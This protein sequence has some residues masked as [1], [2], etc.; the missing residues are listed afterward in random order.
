MQKLLSLKITD[1]I[2][3]IITVSFV[4]VFGV[5]I[6]SIYLMKLSDASAAGEFLNNYFN[7]IKNGVNKLSVFKNSLWHNLIML[8]VMFVS[9]FF[10]IGFIAV[11]A[12]LARKGFIMG[13]TAA[14]FY[15]FYGIKGI[16]MGLSYLPSVLVAVP[17]MLLYASIST[18]ASMEPNKK[19]FLIYYI[20]ITIFI[21]TIFC[22]A[23]LLEGFVTTI[24]MKSASNLL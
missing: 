2:V 1:R 16:L 23:S 22:G 8:F 10:K 11:G 9:G 20:F 3:F 17:A 12:C 21:V 6:G 14:A 13:F 15:R 4:F 5:M 19:K 7:G 18:A 24:F